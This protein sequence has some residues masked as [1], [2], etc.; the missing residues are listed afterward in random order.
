M[1]PNRLRAANNLLLRHWNTIASALQ[2]TLKVTSLYS[3]VLL[4]AADSVP[5]GNNWA[6]GFMRG[7][8]AR[9]TSW[10]EL[11]QSEEHGGCIL[12][13]M[14]LAHEHDPDPEMRPGPVV[15]EKHVE[16]LQMMAASLTLIYRYFEP[17]RR[18]GGLAMRNEAQPS[19]RRNQP[20]VGRNDPCPCG[21]AKKYKHCCAG[22][23]F[24]LQ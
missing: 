5:Q 21:S 9:P 4:A 19:R 10:R 13:I 1:K 6:M 17:H 8:D 16:L 7:V 20:K 3:P 2:Q 24:A 18:S 15:L 12:P 14:L 23:A 11:I 22:T